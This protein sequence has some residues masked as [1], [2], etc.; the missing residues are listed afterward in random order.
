[1]QT[2]DRVGSHARSYTV[3]TRSVPVSVEQQDT[4][5][6][7]LHTCAGALTWI[8][9]QGGKRQ[10]FERDRGQTTTGQVAAYQLRYDDALR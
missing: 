9:P 4:D 7:L 6:L 5:L 10:A 3:S 8:S 2:K 1:M